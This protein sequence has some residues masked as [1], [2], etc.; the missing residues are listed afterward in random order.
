MKFYA[1]G[2]RGLVFLDLKGGKRVIVKKARKDSKAIGFIDNEI[3]FLR[4]LNKLGIGPRLLDVK[5]IGND[6]V[7]V[8]EFIDGITFL[9][10]YKEKEIKNEN[11]KKIIVYVVREILRQCRL[12]DKLKVNKKEMTNPVKHII[13]TK[14]RNIKVENVK[15]RVKMIDFERARFSLK[16]SN[17][18]QFFQFL[19]KI[20]FLRIGKRLISDLKNYKR[21]DGEREFRKLIAHLK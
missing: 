17:V 11:T 8:M 1:K 12:L 14:E 2:K 15:D 3:Y 20:G 6:K 18:T 9:K 10:W 7:I 4:K 13:I 16:P 19:G 21:N 5:R